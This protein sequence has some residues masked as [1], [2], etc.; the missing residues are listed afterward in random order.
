MEYII[1]PIH[2]TALAVAVVGIL[3]ADN[4]AFGWFRGKEATLDLVKLTKYHHTVSW[5]LTFLIVSGSLLFW[6]LRDYLLHS[7][8]FLIKM[9]FVAVL[10]VNSLVIGR[11][12]PIAAT[13]TYA[14]LS[15]KEK[16]PLMII[17]AVSSLAWLSVV[18]AALFLFG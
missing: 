4:L 14:S 9:F 6:P 18:V 15:F 12:L 13:R 2:M 17:G 16:L 5:G 10:V 3:L 8:L 7:T 1:F 11:F